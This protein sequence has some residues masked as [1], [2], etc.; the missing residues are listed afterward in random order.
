M[1][2]ITTVGCKLPHGPCMELG[3]AKN[4]SPDPDYKCAVVLGVEDVAPTL[5]VGP[6]DGR[7][8]VTRV[9]SDLVEAWFKANATSRYVLDKSIFII[10]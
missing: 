8:A 9:A 3:V 10:K 4:G 2:G 7:Y 1:I 5:L 6:K